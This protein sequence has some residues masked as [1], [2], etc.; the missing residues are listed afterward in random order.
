MKEVSF[1]M[2]QEETANFRKAGQILKEVMEYARGLVK[3]EMKLL[4]IAEKIEEKIIK[5]GGKPAFPVNL[6][7]NDIAAHYTS[8][9]D[10][11]S[12]A[13]GLLKVDVGVHVEGC[14]ADGA[15][16]MDLEESEENTRLIEA[17]QKALVA[18][19]QVVRRNVTLGEIGR[20]IQKEIVS[21]GFSPITNLSG[22]EILP[23]EVHAGLTIPNVDTG[24]EMILDEGVYAIEPFATTGAGSVYEG[25]P[26]GIYQLK[27]SRPVRDPLA[28][29]ILKYIEEEYLTLPFCSRWIVKKFGMRALLALSQMEQQ[30]IMHHYRQLIEKGHG[31]VSQAEKTI[32]ITKNGVEIINCSAR[33]PRTLVCG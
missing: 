4:E 31:K 16:S 18:A 33:N 25:K 5:L 15:F 32:L 20:V 2:D 3:P 17:S 7:M 23:Y 19:L 21:C 13:R 22:H 26:S 29:E 30:G 28:R 6:S 8:A 11:Q 24:S 12:L 1:A 27:K 10:D 9:Y 14:V